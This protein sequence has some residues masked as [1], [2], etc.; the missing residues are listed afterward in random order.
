MGLTITQEKVADLER[1]K[2]EVEGLIGKKESDMAAAVR[3]LEDEQNIVAKLQKTIKE[4]QSR[5]EVNEEE[6]EAERQAR[7]QAEKQRCTLSRELDDLTERVDEASGATAAQI[8]LNKKR[9]A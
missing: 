4:L 9:E 1:E 2:K 5:I 6:L 7:S 8:E 3:R